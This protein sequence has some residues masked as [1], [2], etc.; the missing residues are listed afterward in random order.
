MYSLCNMT[1]DRAL[2]SDLK[3]CES[4]LVSTSPIFSRT[5]RSSQ[6]GEGFSDLSA[7]LCLELTPHLQ[8]LRVIDRDFMM[9]LSL[10][11]G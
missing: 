6:A 3:G 5:D 7:W 10:G 8:F 11:G 1:A 9:I 4:T 2:M